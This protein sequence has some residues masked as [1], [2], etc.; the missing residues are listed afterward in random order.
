MTYTLIIHTTDGHVFRRSQRPKPEQTKVVQEWIEMMKKLP[1]T[2][3]FVVDHTKGQWV[4]RLDS[5]TF[6]TVDP[7]VEEQRPPTQ[8]ADQQEQS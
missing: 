8:D 3:P 2:T 4:F 1:G 5:I 7:D 6:M